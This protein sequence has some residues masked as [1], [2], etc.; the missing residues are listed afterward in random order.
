[1]TSSSDVHGEEPNL[2]AEL[3][4]GPLDGVTIFFS[5]AHPEFRPIIPLKDL[6]GRIV[7]RQVVTYRLHSEGPPLSYRFVSAEDWVEPPGSS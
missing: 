4:A 1:M 3:Y 5:A 2:R 6:N 7:K